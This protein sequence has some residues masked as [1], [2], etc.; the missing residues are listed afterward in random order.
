MY[1]TESDPE[2]VLGPTGNNPTPEAI[3]HLKERGNF[4]RSFRDKN[5]SGAGEFRNLDPLTAM[6]MVPLSRCGRM[7]GVLAPRP[8]S[9]R[10]EFNT[11][12]KRAL[13]IV[14]GLLTNPDE[15][16]ADQLVI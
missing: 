10:G 5:E 15:V 16:G 3:D 9:S 11:I 2:A 1:S 12:E 13:N 8:S 7:K 4:V 14:S 6:I